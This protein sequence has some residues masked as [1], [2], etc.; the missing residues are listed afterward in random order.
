MFTYDRATTEIS[1]WGR[2]VKLIIGG[3]PDDG[4]FFVGNSTT[5]YGIDYRQD[6]QIGLLEKKV[7]SLPQSECLLWSLKFVKHET[8]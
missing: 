5:P 3:A 1:E 8:L 6:N 4:T 2:S 7:A